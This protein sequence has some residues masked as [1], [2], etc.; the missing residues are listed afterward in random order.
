MYF[1]IWSCDYIMWVS[2]SEY[3]GIGV[4]K[5]LR[6]ANKLCYGFGDKHR[7]ISKTLSYLHESNDDLWNACTI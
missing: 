5:Y 4:I 2:I 7:D 1:F 6:H 3:V